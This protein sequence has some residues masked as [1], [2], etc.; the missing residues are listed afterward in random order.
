MRRVVYVVLKVDHWELWTLDSFR[1]DH[2]CLFFKRGHFVS[3]LN[4]SRHQ[5][6]WSG[7]EEGWSLCEFILSGKQEDLFIALKF[8]NFF[9][10]I[11]QQLMQSA[12]H[13]NWKRSKAQS[14][15]PF[16]THAT[17]LSMSAPVDDH[18]IRT[19]LNIIHPF[20][21]ML[22]DLMPWC[23]EMNQCSTFI[24]SNIH[25]SSWMSLWL[26][27]QEEEKDYPFHLIIIC[28]TYYLVEWF[29]SCAW[30]FLSSHISGSSQ[31]WQEV[32]IYWEIFF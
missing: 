6:S 18:S 12:L 27:R 15:A 23:V 19:A 28:L 9:I 20:S 32:A 16:N 3:Y 7:R 17:Y 22:W 1:V 2:G 8:G 30:E 29:G 25:S 31:K 21:W 4:S 13:T 14:N 10:Q 26:E 11:R 24:Y 5:K